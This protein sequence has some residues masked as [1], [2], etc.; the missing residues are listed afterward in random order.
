MDLKVKEVLSFFPLEL[1]RNLENH[2]NG[3]LQEIRLR[4]NKPVCIMKNSENIV[5][6]DI[7][8]DTDTV[9]NVFDNI[10]ENSVYAHQ[11]EI[12]QGF[13]T[14][15]GGN[16]VGV[17]GTA[18]V[19]NGKIISVKNI[20]SLNFRVSHDFIGC[21]D[22]IIDKCSDNIIIAGPPSSGKTTLLRDIARNISKMNKKVCV[23]DERFEI[24]GICGEFDL[25]D[26]CDVLSGYKKAYGISL[27]LRTLSPQYII[28]DEIGTLFECE[29]VFESLN[30]GVNI[31]T[32]VHS[33]GK[34][35]FFKRPVCKK[36]IESRFFNHIVFLSEKAGEIKEIYKLN[37]DKICEF[38]E[39]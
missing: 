32:S 11:D 18:V 4:S 29:S 17:C 16:R 9:E 10:C 8:A 24:G 2:L 7:I 3:N 22:K 25:G 34:K 35:E 38:A 33:N 30:S 28:F 13:V 21:S 12:N 1:S 26:M 5:L 37:G 15:K 36:L 23:V 39:Y 14:V 6:K 20:S 27:A 19:E 31:I